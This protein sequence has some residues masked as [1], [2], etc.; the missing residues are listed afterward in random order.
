[1]VKNLSQAKR[2]MS[3]E[4]RIETTNEFYKIKGV[5]V[6]Q[7]IPTPTRNI[8]GRIV[9][10]EQST[11]DFMGAYIQHDDYI[12]QEIAIPVAFEA[13]ETS[14]ETNFPLTKRYKGR[15]VETILEHQREFLKKWPGHGFVLINFSE[16]GECY[17]VDVDF[18]EQYYLAMY[19]GGRK[20]IPIADFMERWKVDPDDYLGHFQE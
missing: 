12:N 8:K 20:S 10:A 14:S 11:V 1:M 17:A 15:D 2:G 16:R 18:I 13:K 6:I 3:F 19:K 4:K 9:Y 5:G 7:K